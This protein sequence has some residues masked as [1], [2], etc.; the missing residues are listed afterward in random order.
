MPFDKNKRTSMTGIADADAFY[1]YLCSF[2]E[3][4]SGV[5]KVCDR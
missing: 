3:K 2:A 4:M 1:F 5:K